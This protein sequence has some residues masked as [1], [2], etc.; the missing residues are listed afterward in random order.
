MERLG[1]L[2]AAS[3]TCQTESY[4]CEECRDVGM[5]EVSPRVFEPCKC[6]YAKRARRRLER[7][8]LQYVLDTLTFERYRADEP[9]QK[10]ALSTVRAWVHVTVLGKG[11]VRPWLFMGGAV[12]SGK[13]HL[14]TAA[15]GELLRANMDVLY[16]LW[17]ETARSLKANIN[18]QEE[19]ERIIYPLKTVD[20]LYIDDLFKTQRDRVQTNYRGEPYRPTVQEQ[21]SEAETRIAFELLD[22]RYRMNRATVISCEWLMDELMQIDDGVASRIYERSNGYRVGIGRAEGRNMRLNGGATA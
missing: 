1:T 22:A 16:I 19:Y 9:W 3:T 12:G 7:S 14:C 21:V 15:C 5:I 8:G 20:V 11:G 4:E 17:R 18:D 13:T 2:E 10:D 6:Q